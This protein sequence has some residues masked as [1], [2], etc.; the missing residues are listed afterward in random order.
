MA[1]LFRLT[2]LLKLTGPSFRQISSFSLPATSSRS[3]TVA[4]N[5]RKKQKFRKTVPAH[6]PPVAFIE[7][8]VARLPQPERIQRKEEFRFYPNLKTDDPLI[9]LTDE[10]K[11]I[12]VP[13]LNKVVSSLEAKGFKFILPWSDDSAIEKILNIMNEIT[14]TSKL[15]L[16]LLL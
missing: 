7:D 16:K 6:S 12:G 10:E 9:E 8:D 2:N 11:H 15:G 14:S 1:S 5:Q 13:F 3:Y 4:A